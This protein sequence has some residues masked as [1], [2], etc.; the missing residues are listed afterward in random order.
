[1]AGFT[2]Y[3]TATSVFA[4]H[5]AD[6]AAVVPYL[7]AQRLDGTWQK[8]SDDIGFPAGL[9]RTMTADLSGKLP[10]GT[11]RIRIWTNLKVYWDQVLIDTTPAGAVPSERREVP[12]LDASLAYRGFPRE[13]PGKPAADLT[14]VYDEVSP[15]GPYARHRGF[16]TRYGDVR[17]LVSGIDDRFTIFGAGDQVSLEFDATALPPARDG[18]TR[19]Y[20]L[21]V[22]G[23][24]KDMD[25]Y[26]AHA[27]TVTPLPFRNMRTYPYPATLHYPDRNRDYLLDW[28]TREVGAEAWPTYR[29]AFTKR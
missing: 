19:D 20:L 29:F 26:A 17:P 3:F 2:D 24:V 4:A 13:V 10:P 18:W 27:Q 7:E 5:Q 16:Y 6:V 28:N 14:Y 1:M 21:F 12:L 8:V 23:Y 9:R 22:D 25:F 15:Y 11:R